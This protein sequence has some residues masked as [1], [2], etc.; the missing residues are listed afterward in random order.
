MAAV[1]GVALGCGGRVSSS[2]PNA[3]VTPSCVVTC[4][5]Q[6]FYTFSLESTDGSEPTWLGSQCDVTPCARGM[7]CEVQLDGGTF[8]EGVCE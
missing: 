1:C 5:E 8:A 3:C 2:A 7:S 4:D 6:A